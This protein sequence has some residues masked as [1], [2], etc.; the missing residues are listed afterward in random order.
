M[1]PPPVR[2]DILR[3]LHEGHQGIEKT[4]RLARESV[5]WPGINGD[6]EH[7]CKACPFCQQMQPEQAR[8][9]LI[10]HERPSTPWTKLGTDLFELDGVT[11]LIIS[12]Y[13]SRYP[14]IR[15]L[16]E[17]SSAAV[18]EATK[19]VLAMLGTPTEIVSDNGPQFLTAYK[20]FCEQWVFATRHQVRDTHSPTDSL[21]DRSDT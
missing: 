7:M 8:E 20:N 6:I 4:R 3:Q 5:F 1:I 16:T 21:S 15:R 18:I 13:Y 14:V 19:E 11:Y 10:T 2:E 12:D 17:T 9:P